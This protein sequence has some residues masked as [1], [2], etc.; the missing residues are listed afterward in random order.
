MKSEILL[1]RIEFNDMYNAD[2]KQMEQNEQ[3]SATNSISKMQLAKTKAL[4]TKFKK[5]L[6]TK[7][8]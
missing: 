2:W 4:L 5:Q 6:N 3:Y 7:N 8:S 1:F